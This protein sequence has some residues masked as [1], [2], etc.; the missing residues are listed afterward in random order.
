MRFT[1]W[2]KSGFIG[3]EPPDSRRL[4]KEQLKDVQL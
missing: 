1:K 3:S 2:R 4:L